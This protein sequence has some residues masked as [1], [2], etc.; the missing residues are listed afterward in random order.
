MKDPSRVRVTGPL[1]P[2]ARGFRIE[3]ARQGTIVAPA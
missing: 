1:G 2:Y 3:L